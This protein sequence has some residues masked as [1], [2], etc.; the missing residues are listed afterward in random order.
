M[1]LHISAV[2]TALSPGTDVLSSREQPA[3]ASR[4]DVQ[5]GMRNQEYVCCNF[6]IVCKIS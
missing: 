6:L 4:A 5:A 1:G 3:A 2:S